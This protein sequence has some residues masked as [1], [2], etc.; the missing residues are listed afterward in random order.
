MRHLWFF[1]RLAVAVILLVIVVT[2]VD[3]GEAAAQVRSAPWWVFVVPPALLVLNSGI[4]AIRIGVLL[5]APRPGFL[6]VLASVLIGNFFGIFLPS[7]G[8][9][10]AK[11]VALGR[12]TGDFETALAALA[13]SRLLE[14]I[15]WGLL[16]V[17]GALVV[18]PDRLPGYVWLAWLTAAGFSAVLL[19]VCGFGPRLGALPLPAGL[20]AR[21]ARLLAFRPP[22]RHVYASL[23][24]SVPFAAINC[25]VIWLVQRA[26]G[27]PLSYGEIMGVAPTLDVVISLPVSVSGVGV[28]EAVYVDGFGAY[29]VAAPVALAI[30]FTRWT[31]ELLRAGVGGLVF[32]AGASSGGS[33]GDT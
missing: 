17:W 31:G 10:A 12:A 26:Y 6:A 21:V 30:A 14:L 1:V 13:T 3:P 15:P 32:L 5:P 2:R 7:G 11:V 25:L 20:R 29:G 24:A 23:A 16:C 18:L 33:R 9:E 4:H 8:G 22:R 28:R 27:G 19:A